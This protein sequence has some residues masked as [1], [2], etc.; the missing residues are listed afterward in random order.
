MIRPGRQNPHITTQMR[1]M[2]IMLNK[3]TGYAPGLSCP[4][5]LTSPS[6]LIRLTSF[7]MF[8]PIYQPI[9]V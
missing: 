7:F 3:I 4:S 5:F 6:R 1:I 2:Y 8:K 9:S